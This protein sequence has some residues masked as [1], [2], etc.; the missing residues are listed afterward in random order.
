[1]SDAACAGEPGCRKTLAW[2]DDLGVF[3][4]E[5]QRHADVHVFAVLAHK[6]QATLNPLDVS[7]WEFYVVPTP[8]LN[9]N[10][11]GQKTVG[12]G[13]LHSSPYAMSVAYGELGARILA[14]G[15]QRA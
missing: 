7:Q 10:L 12:L 11:G 2:S 5:P 4:G 3:Y 9:D 1:M 6:S 13:M 14:L 8:W 15:P